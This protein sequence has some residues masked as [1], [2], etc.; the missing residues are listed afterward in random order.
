MHSIS[1]FDRRDFELQLLGSL[2]LGGQSPDSLTIADYQSVLGNRSSRPFSPFSKHI[3]TGSNYGPAGQLAHQSLNYPAGLGGASVLHHWAAE[4]IVVLPLVPPILESPPSLWALESRVRAIESKSL[5]A[6]NLSFP[7][8]VDLPL[9]LSRGELCH[10]RRHQCSVHRRSLAASP[11]LRYTFPCPRWKAGHPTRR[12]R[13]TK[14]CRRYQA[15]MRFSGVTACSLALRV[16]FG[17]GWVQCESLRSSSAVSALVLASVHLLGIPAT[18][19]GVGAALSIL[20]ALSRA[21]AASVPVLLAVAG[22]GASAPDDAESA[23]FQ[24]SFLPPRYY[25]PCGFD[26]HRSSL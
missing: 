7:V 6:G 24:S 2:D 4:F 9:R 14:W 18:A 10:P 19:S 16:N 12:K 25:L 15:G 13:L 17:S 22:N 3:E 20:V 11:I 8:E 26:R 21:S 5:A 23:R 1:L